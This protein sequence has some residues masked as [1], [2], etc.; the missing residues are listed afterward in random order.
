MKKKPK[1]MLQ[2]VGFDFG[3]YLKTIG[4][5]DGGEKKKKCGG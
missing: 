2:N 1:R 5:L 4:P 3:I